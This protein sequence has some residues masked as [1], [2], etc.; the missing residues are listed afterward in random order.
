M[1]LYLPLKIASTLREFRE[2]FATPSAIPD[3]SHLRRFR[4][5]SC[6]TFQAEWAVVVADALVDVMAA[7]VALDAGK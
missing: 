4:D 3:R 7:M 5:R 1:F 6:D 2:A